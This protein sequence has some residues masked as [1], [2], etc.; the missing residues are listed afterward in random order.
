[1]CL[2]TLRMTHWLLCTRVSIACHSKVTIC[3]WSNFI[4]DQFLSHVLFRIFSG[5][6]WFLFFVEI[7]PFF[8]LFNFLKYFCRRVNAMLS[9]EL[10]RLWLSLSKSKSKQYSQFGNTMRTFLRNNRFIWCILADTSSHHL[11]IKPITIQFSA[12]INNNNSGSGSA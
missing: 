9:Y 3:R 4:S 11:L 12:E 8:I 6:C 2:P 10:V 7:R 5:F 1:M